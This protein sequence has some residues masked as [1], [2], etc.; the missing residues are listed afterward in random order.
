[1]LFFSGFANEHSA[2]MISGRVA[3][4]LGGQALYLIPRYLIKKP[5]CH[6][7]YTYRPNI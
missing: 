7:K 6:T 2:V 5:T 1:M 3:L 4:G